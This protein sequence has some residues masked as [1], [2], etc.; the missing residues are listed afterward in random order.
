MCGICGHVNIDD[1]A[2]IVRMADAMAHRGPDD[3]GYFTEGNVHLGHRRLS[4]IDIAGGHQPMIT[5]DGRLV[6]VFN[7]EIYNFPELREQMLAR[8]HSFETRSDTEVLLHLFAEQGPEA[9]HALNGM[10]AFAVHDRQTGEIFLARDRIGI[11][12]LYYLELPNRFLFA[13]EVKSLLCYSDWTPTINPRAIHDYLALRYVPGDRVVFQEIRRLPAGHWLRYKDGRVTVQRYWSPP[14]YDGPYHRRDGEYQEQFEALMEQS[15]RRR[16]ISDVSFGAYLSGGLDSSVIAALMSRLVSAPVKTFSVGFDYEHDELNE[17]ADT[18]KYL[19]CDH[20]EIPCRAEDVLLLPKIVHHM[21]E[22]MGD[23]IIIPMYQLS[24]EA[25]KEVTVILTGE[26]GDEV[27]GGYL[28]HKIMW[29]GNVY[30]HA[31]P[32]P[33]RRWAV[34]P[35]LSLAPAAVMNIAFKYPAYLG[36]RGKQKALDYL[37]LTEP[38]RIADAYR[39]LISLFD[40]RDTAGLYTPDFADGLR[41]QLD[42]AGPMYPPIAPGGPYLNRLLELQFRHWLPDNMLLRQDK[43]GMANAIEGRVPY[44]DHELVEFAATLP[45]RLKLRRMAGKYILRTYAEKLLPQEVARRKKM[46]FYVPME[47]YFQQSTFQELM[48]EL[49]SESSVRNRGIFQPPMVA[50]LREQMRRSEFLLVKQVFSLMI[51]ELWF[52]IFVDRTW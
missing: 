47:N 36:S 39:H 40:D 45:P 7:G 43:T 38:D 52:R 26:G 24:R 19:G 41:R 14:R 8:G 6:I 4:I 15:V 27:F 1:D 30:R 28:F 50:V 31:L 5:P 48:A 25:K 35:L 13:S 21:D 17:A 37:R 44:L 49:L 3:Y 33:V 16:L 11:K 29:A 42:A 46:P 51:L 20:H 10:F 34:E 18:A 2:L 9:L 12:P 23:G 22:P 32:G